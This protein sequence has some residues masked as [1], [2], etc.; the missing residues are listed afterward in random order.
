MRRVMRVRVSDRVAAHR[1]S[2]AMRRGTAVQVIVPAVA[3]HV[4][5]EMR[6]VMRVPVIGHAVLTPVRVIDP[7]AVHH[8]V[9]EMRPADAHLAPVLS[10]VVPGLMARHPAVRQGA[11]EAQMVLGHAGPVRHRRA[12]RRVGRARQIDLG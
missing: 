4:I 8:E 2:G 11:P 7:V 5:A 1:A 9:E 10:A 12:V 3:H 6:R